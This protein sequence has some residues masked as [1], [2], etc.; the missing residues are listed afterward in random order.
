VPRFELVDGKSNKF[1]DIKLSGS[2]LVTTFG[3]IGSSG[4]KQLK[5]LGSTAAAQKEYDKLVASKVKKGYEQ[6][7]GICG[8]LVFGDQRDDGDGPE[9]RYASATE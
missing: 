8:E 2:S 4:Q 3:R 9:D 1:W 7:G 5:E 6:V